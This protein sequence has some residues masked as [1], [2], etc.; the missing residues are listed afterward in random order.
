MCVC[1]L[2]PVPIEFS[3]VNEY[4]VALFDFESRLLTPCVYYCC[5]CFSFRR[6]PSLSVYTWYIDLPLSYEFE[7][8]NHLKRRHSTNAPS[9]FLSLICT[10]QSMHRASWGLIYL[11][12]KEESIAIPLWI[13][14]KDLP[15][16]SGHL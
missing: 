11:L 15:V 1:D 14:Y 6:T 8:G 2:V 4:R 12:G 16:A 7:N 5:N 9:F 10:A 3:V 13:S